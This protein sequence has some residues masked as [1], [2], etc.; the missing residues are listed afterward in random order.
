M[1]MKHIFILKKKKKSSSHDRLEDY[2]KILTI[3]DRESSGG[4]LTDE[5]GCDF[6]LPSPAKENM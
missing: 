2:V 1:T 4:G 6:A 5:V 3:L